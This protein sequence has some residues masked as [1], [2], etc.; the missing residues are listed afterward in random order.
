MLIID[1]NQPMSYIYIDFNSFSRYFCLLQEQQ[2]LYASKI[3][4]PTRV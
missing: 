4:F 3:R 2:V 1:L